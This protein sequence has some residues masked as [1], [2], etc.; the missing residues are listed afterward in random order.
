[1]QLP[2]RPSVAINKV[3]NHHIIIGAETISFSCVLVAVIF[4]AE[5]R[6]FFLSLFRRYCIS[7][8]LINFCAKAVTSATNFLSS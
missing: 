2:F 6:R 5:W 1:V 3:A 4:G 8:Q 7:Q